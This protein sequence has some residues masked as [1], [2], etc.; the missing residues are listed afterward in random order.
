MKVKICGLKTL[1]EALAALDAGADYLGFNF[2]PP[3]PRYV[4]PL[5]CAGITARLSERGYSAT[6]VGVFVNEPADKITAILGDCGL[7]LAQLCGDEPARVLDFLGQRAFKAL[8]PRTTNDLKKLEQK[9]PRRQDAPAWLVDAFHP[10]EF[11]GTGENADWRLAGELAQRAAIFLA[12]GL[13]PDNVA[14]AVEQVKPWGVDVAS[15][16]E[17][18][19]GKKDPDKVRAF[20]HSARKMHILGA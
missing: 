10:G 1:D 8:R 17:S 12:G 14:R 15:G 7:H 2:Y 20:V 3:S 18:E 11:G 13:N 4:P 19:P 5:T 16:V 6:F 9:Y